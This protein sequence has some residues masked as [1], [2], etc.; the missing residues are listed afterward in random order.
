M[1]NL[2][3]SSLVLA[4]LLTPQLSPAH[5]QS[6]PGAPPDSAQH[7]ADRQLDELLYADEE[8]VQPAAKRRGSDDDMR[9]PSRRHRDGNS[10]RQSPGANKRDRY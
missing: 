1:K 7:R 9:K 2:L 3:H 4:S 6:T 10:H 5:A 8:F